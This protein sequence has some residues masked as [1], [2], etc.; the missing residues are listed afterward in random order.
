MMFYSNLLNL[1]NIK[2]KRQKYASFANG[3]NTNYDSNLLPVKYSINTYNFDYTDGALKDGIGINIP[4]FRYNKTNP[5]MI[6]ELIFPN[7]YQIYGCW[8]FNRWN[9]KSNSY[10][11]FVVIYTGDRKLYYNYL[12][13]H[14]GQMYEVKEMT[15]EEK[16]NV[17]SY[18]LNG[19]D[20]LLIVGKDEG[21][22][23]SKLE[24]FPTHHDNIPKIS[25]MCIH[26]ERLFIT[27]EGEKKSIWFSDDLNPTNFNASLSEGG[28]IE[29]HDEFG[30]LNK[31]VSF[32]GYLYVFRDYNIARVSAYADQESF[33]VTQLYVSNGKIIDGTVC[34]C[35][36]K[37]M[38]LASDGLYSFNGSSCVKLDLGID[39]MFAGIDNADAV[40]GY[41]NGYYYLSCK[42]NFLDN[43]K[44]GCENDEYYANNALL[45]INVMTG[46][47]S[48]L[49]GYDIKEI[50]VI[51]DF[52]ESYV[53][54][55]VRKNHSYTLGM[56][57]NSGTF[58]GE[59]THKVWISP[60]TDF[61]YPERDKLIN[62]VYLESLNDCVVSIN[63]DGK[64][65]NY[66]V[67]GREGYQTIK[68]YVKG[69]KV[70]I[71]FVSDKNNTKISNPQVEVGIL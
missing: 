58:F 53:M 57:D 11:P 5:D 60:Q 65:T 39:N 20:V 45:K 62:E 50:T 28:F 43:E 22:Y 1:K 34:T 10:D 12:Y 17:I 42:L 23:V 14:Y 15:F 54:V 27:T 7:M 48:I 33:F 30:R 63:C 4:K 59:P 70:S 25:S 41:S 21:M 69:N 3:I 66:E 8:Y 38:F 67:K 13:D 37:I 35:G 6:K 18:N 44:L 40:A 46:Q 32:E 2:Y 19:E 26:Y 55:I 31:V 56:L 29:M 64:I 16:P 49:R 52:L 61:G 71:N 68:P 51:N 36:N 24:T 47:M 9:D